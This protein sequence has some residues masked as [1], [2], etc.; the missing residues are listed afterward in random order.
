MSLADFCIVVF[1]FGYKSE[2]LSV[3]SISNPRRSVHSSVVPVPLDVAAPLP[4]RRRQW[5]HL[6]RM[7]ARRPLPIFPRIRIRIR[8]P[9]SSLRVRST[10]DIKDSYLKFTKNTTLTG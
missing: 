4:E 10:F 5:H 2:V 8:A 3:V 6:P 9:L 7:V 1:V